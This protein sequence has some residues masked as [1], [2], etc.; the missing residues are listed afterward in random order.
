MARI[1]RS[2]A[3]SLALISLNRDFHHP[4]DSLV[5]L[6][7]ATIEKPYGWVFFYQSRAFLETGDFTFQLVGNG[8]VV[9]RDDGTV[10]TLGSARPPE[11][12]IAAYEAGAGPA[13][14]K[15]GA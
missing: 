3:E 2:E 4:P 14:R 8:P 7:D 12:E 5:I 15:P 11:E 13:E 6:S 9:V 10:R 1:T